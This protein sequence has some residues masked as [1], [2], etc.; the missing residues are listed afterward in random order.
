MSGENDT[1][2]VQQ[3]N[4]SLHM[5]PEYPTF[6]LSMQQFAIAYMFSYLLSLEGKRKA[7]LKRVSE[8]IWSKRTALPRI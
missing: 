4:A 5:S 1:T 7:G 6:V 2:N 3:I 8:E